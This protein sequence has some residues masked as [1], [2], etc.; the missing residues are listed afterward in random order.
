[1]SFHTCLLQ[2][3]ELL[4][5]SRRPCSTVSSPNTSIVKVIMLELE[6]MLGKPCILVDLDK[7]PEADL[8]VP[9]KGYV[10]TM[11]ACVNVR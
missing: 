2:L 4:Q 9:E 7:K 11:I 5:I 8:C 3:T 6:F 10:S 1:M